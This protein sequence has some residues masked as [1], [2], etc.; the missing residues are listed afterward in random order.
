MSMYR[1]MGFENLPRGLTVCLV[2]NSMSKPYCPCIAQRLFWLPNCG[3][4]HLHYFVVIETTYST[5]YSVPSIQR[6]A[7]ADFISIL[8]LIMVPSD[9][10]LLEGLCWGTF[11]T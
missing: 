5:S 6:R 2:V 3:S 4:W 1:I 10:V 9:A 8:S 7:T 11:L